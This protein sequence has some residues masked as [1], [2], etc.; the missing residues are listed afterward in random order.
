MRRLEPAVPTIVDDSAQWPIY[1]GEGPTG[2]ALLA[3]FQR[4]CRTDSVDYESPRSTRAETRQMRDSAQR[5]AEALEQLGRSWPQARALYGL[6]LP[7]VLLAP[8][9]HLAG[10]TVSSVPGVLWAATK[11][12]W[13]D[14][15]TQEFLLH[16]LVHTTL[17]LEERRYG[18]YRDMRL[19]LNEENLIPSAI[20]QDRRP[21]DK[22]LHSIV[23]ACELLLARE[24]LGLDPERR[25]GVHPDS[26]S[27][28]A[29]TRR[30]VTAARAL[31]LDRLLMPRPIEILD[32][33]ALHLDRVPVGR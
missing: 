1:V 26:D 10:G 27:L 5:V 20:R 6:L 21:L 4:A 15:D 3:A 17:F 29:G 28:R 16:E 31:D 33:C 12:T 22:V 8:A 18:F 2:Q 9:R 25:G 11:P 13:S 30:S 32:R 23:V 19:L 24:A 14:V 7:V